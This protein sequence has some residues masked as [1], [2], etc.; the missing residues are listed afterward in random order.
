VSARID[1]PEVDRLAAEGWRVHL[2]PEPST[3]DLRRELAKGSLPAAFH[4]TATRNPDRP[5]LSIDGAAATHGE[6]D[7]RAA[8][9]AGWLHREGIHRGD[10]VVVSGA[11]SLGLVAGYLGVL[12]AGAT[13]VLANPVLTEVEL[14]HLVSDSSAVLAL[15]DG[16]A[17]SRLA[18][19]ARSDGP[20]RAAVDLA[21]LERDARDA[22]PADPPAATSDDVA[23]LAYTSGTTG[24]PKAVPLTHGNLLSSIRAVMLAWRWSEDDVLIHALPLSHQ[25]GLGGVHVALLSGSRAVIHAKFDAAAIC[26]AIRSERGTVLFGVPAVYERLLAAEGADTAALG[27][28]R[29]LVSGSAPLSPLLAERVADIAGEVPLERYGTTESGLDVSNPYDGPRKPGTVGLPLPG[30]ELALVDDDGAPVGRGDTGEIVLRGPQVFSGYRGQPEATA[31]AFLP[32]GWFRTG[33]L[34]RLVPSDS[35]LEISGRAKDLIITGGMNVYPREVELALEQSA[36]VARAAVVGV[37]SERWGEEVVAAI[38]PRAE[39]TPDADG[40]LA[41]AR[42][43]LAPYKC[44]KRFVVVDELP[45]NAMGKVVSAEVARL[46]TEAR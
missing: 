35:Y 10:P 46:V 2:G 21:G 32:G 36:D 25:H 38:V 20:L 16:G 9:V 13:V 27:E 5:A 17:R 6:I 1:T 29:L 14:A 15:A 31:A 4:A 3:D 24:K 12:R 45:V 33:D 11:N 39:R 40:L 28:L 23:L 7:G 26:D 37:P 44:P 41:F 19:I 18:S 8:K 43:R 30:V 34:G 42:S 22:A